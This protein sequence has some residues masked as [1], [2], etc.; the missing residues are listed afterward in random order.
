MRTIITNISINSGF[1]I[2]QNLTIDA[3][4]CASAVACTRARL[5]RALKAALHLAMHLKRHLM[6]ALVGQGSM[7]PVVVTSWSQVPTGKRWS[8]GYRAN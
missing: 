2:C 4:R 5:P 1:G 3:D 7:V 8:I 6:A